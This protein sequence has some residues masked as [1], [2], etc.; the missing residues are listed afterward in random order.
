M[1]LESDLSDVFV[2]AVLLDDFGDGDAFATTELVAALAMVD[3]H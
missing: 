2:I 3:N 1:T